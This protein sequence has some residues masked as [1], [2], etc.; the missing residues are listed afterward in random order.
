MFPRELD[1]LTRQPAATAPAAAEFTHT[2]RDEATHLRGAVL[3]LRERVEG[4]NGRR[5]GK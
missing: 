5:V 2:L 1:Q 4:R 3:V